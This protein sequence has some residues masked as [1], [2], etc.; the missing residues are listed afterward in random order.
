M[1]RWPLWLSALTALVLLGTGCG[2]FAEGVKE[3]V[4]AG[5]GASASASESKETPEYMLASIDAGHPLESDDG[6]V[7]DYARALDSLEGKCSNARTRLGDM[8]VKGQELLSDKGVE[9][10]LLSILRNVRLSIPD[11]LPAGTECADI[12]AAYVLLRAGG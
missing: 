11:S 2:D 3:G 8:A 4:E 9:E 6:T 1:A 12:Y 7:D 5:S 10:S